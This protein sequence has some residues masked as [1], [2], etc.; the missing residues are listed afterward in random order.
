MCTLV[1]PTK[2]ERKSSYVS[3]G[4]KK[5]KSIEKLLLLKLNTNHLPRNWFRYEAIGMSSLLDDCAIWLIRIELI[6]TY[7]QG[8]RVRSH[9][10]G[11]VKL[12]SVVI[13]KTAPTRTKNDAHNESSNTSTHVNGTWSSKVNDTGSPE[14]LGSEGREKSIGWPEGVGTNGVDESCQENEYNLIRIWG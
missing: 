10:F 5:Y 14:W 9:W 13:V 4:I 11:F 3:P 2:P 8:D 6:K 12:N 7:L 1:L